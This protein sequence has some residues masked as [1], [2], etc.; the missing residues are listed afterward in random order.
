VI[1]NAVEVFIAEFEAGPAF[2]DPHQTRFDGVRFNVIYADRFVFYIKSDRRPCPASLVVGTLSK[3]RP[4]ITVRRS[5]LESQERAIM[6]GVARLHPK[7]FPPAP[8]R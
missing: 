2:L 3:T 4:V 8:S 1:L 7:A 5:W 6:Q